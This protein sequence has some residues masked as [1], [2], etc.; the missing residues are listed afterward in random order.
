M[1]ASDGAS[2]QLRATTS[3]T[4]VK[5]AGHEEATFALMRTTIGGCPSLYPGASRAYSLQEFR[6]CSCACVVEQHLVGGLSEPCCA[7]TVAAAGSSPAAVQA[8]SGWLGLSPAPRPPAG[9]AAP[10]YSSA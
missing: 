2:R 3:T 5:R 6:C 7:A 10:S 8:G 9:A 1:A 4:T